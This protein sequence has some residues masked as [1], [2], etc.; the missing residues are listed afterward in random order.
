ME[1]KPELALSLI[2]TTVSVGV[3]FGIMKTNMEKLWEE[4]KKVKEWKDNQ[5]AVCQSHLIEQER[6]VGEV[7]SQKGV[8]DEQFREIIRR[9]DTIEKIVDRRI[10]EDN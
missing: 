6:I 5:N 2:A 4:M 3:S 7:K 10:N 9:L 8:R 1:L